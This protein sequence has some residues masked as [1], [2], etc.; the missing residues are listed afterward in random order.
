MDGDCIHYEG[1]YCFPID[2]TR[3]FAIDID[4]SLICLV[5]V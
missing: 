2:C 1:E 5:F 4:K 3:D